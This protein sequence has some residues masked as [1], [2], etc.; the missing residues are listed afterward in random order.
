M[1]YN[2]KYMAGAFAS[3]DMPN[4]AKTANDYTNYQFDLR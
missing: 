3:T 1:P 4:F 2:G